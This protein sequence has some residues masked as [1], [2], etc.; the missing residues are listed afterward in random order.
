MMRKESNGSTRQT[1]SALLS[2]RAHRDRDGDGWP[3]ES[4]LCPFSDH[5]EDS[6]QDGRGDACDGVVR[7]TARDDAVLAIDRQGETLF[8]DLDMVYDEITWRLAQ[9]P[10]P[11]V[12]QSDRSGFAGGV[13]IQT[14][15][16][17]FFGE[18]RPAGN[19]YLLRKDGQPWGYT[20][21]VENHRITGTSHEGGL[22]AIDFGT[23]EP[24]SLRPVLI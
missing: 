18:G 16:L 24:T 11:W 9:L 7:L 20:S 10:H 8:R 2:E 17:K 21:A 19:L 12:T 4:D 23:L 1:S 5:G 13:A 3:D 22:T 14:K 6:D 15:T